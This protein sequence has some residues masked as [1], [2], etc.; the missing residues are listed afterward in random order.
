[1]ERFYFDCKQ[2]DDANTNWTHCCS[3]SV[4]N[5]DADLRIPV[6]FHLVSGPLRRESGQFMWN[7]NNKLKACFLKLL[8]FYYKMREKVR[9]Q[10]EGTET[11]CCLWPSV[12]RSCE[13]QHGQLKR[14]WEPRLGPGATWCLF[15]WQLVLFAG[16][17]WQREKRVTG[18]TILDQIDIPQR[19]PQQ[20]TW[21]LFLRCDAKLSRVERE[22]HTHVLVHKRCS[23]TTA[24]LLGVER[25]RG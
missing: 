21:H 11:F 20:R 1:M 5:G 13:V 22:A 15:W 23:G 9:G 12:Y 3:S 10:L 6:H 7:S 16:I 2:D 25:L 19:I 14:W 4:M 17:R 8:R 18:W 24:A